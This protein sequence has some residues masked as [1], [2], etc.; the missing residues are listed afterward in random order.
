VSTPASEDLR[1]KPIGELVGQLGSE[2]STLVRQEMELAKVTVR[3]EIDRAS[4]R[5]RDD[6]DDAREEMGAKAQH[7]GK[8]A[9][10]AVAAAVAAILAL[11]TLTAFLVLALDGAVDNWLAALI[12]GLVWV[13]A[14]AVLLLLARAESRR[15]GSVAPL[16]LD[17][18]KQDARDAVDNIQADVR[19]SAESI[20]EDVQWARTQSGSESR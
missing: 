17:R 7:A 4:M 20:K 1:Q 12:I 11:G 3:D 13:A 5:L 15:I 14:T 10:L 9:A 18:M 8:A 19:Q 6:I 2:I 16:A